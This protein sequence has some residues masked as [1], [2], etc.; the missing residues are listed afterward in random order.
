[1]TGRRCSVRGTHGAAEQGRQV[2]AVRAADLGGR[3]VVPV[4]PG[5]FRRR[6][7]SVGEHLLTGGELPNGD[8]GHP[9]RILPRE[10]AV[11][12]RIVLAVVAHQNPADRG[13]LRGQTA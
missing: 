3:G 1:A 12:Q 8:R 6:E 9:V 4:P 2:I 10:L 11:Q 13:E 7:S 5:F